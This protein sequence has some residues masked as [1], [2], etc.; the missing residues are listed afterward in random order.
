MDRLLKKKDSK[1][2]QLIKPTSKITARNKFGCYPQM[3]YR[4][5]SDGQRTLSLAH[6]IE[7]PIKATGLVSPVGHTVKLCHVCKL[8]P[9]KYACSKTHKP[10]C[11]L[12]CYK[13]NLSKLSDG[14]L[15][16]TTSVA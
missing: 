2:N 10:L 7:Y 6:G 16:P 1:I 14:I 13:T 8:N 9:K 11:S 15:P 3:T 5:S 12:E 4:I